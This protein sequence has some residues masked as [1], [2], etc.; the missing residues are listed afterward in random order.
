MTLRTWIPMTQI[1]SELGLAVSPQ[2]RKVRSD[3]RFE[4]QYF[5][6]PGGKRKLLYI[7]ED[8]VRLWIETLEPDKIKRAFESSD[9]V[10][11]ILT[12]G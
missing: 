9:T 3:P 4:A 5:T 7:P 2:S 10:F 11:D 8:Q 1:C 6:T 12:R